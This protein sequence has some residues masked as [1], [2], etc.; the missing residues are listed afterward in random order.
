MIDKINQLLPHR[1]PM[2]MI[3]ALVHI[4]S[5]SATAIKTFS[6]GDYGLDGQYV[7][8]PLLIEC[9]AQTVAA[10]QGYHARKAGKAAPKGMLVGVND[11]VINYPPVAGSEL[12][13]NIKIDRHIGP[14]CFTK[15]YIRQQGRVIAQG[16]LKLYIE[17]EQG[18]EK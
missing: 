10:A 15:A 11:F 17:L 4:E 16:E 2:I 8:E 6:A 18:M 3:D 1:E 12:E 13:L 7:S 14:F 5:D 9:L